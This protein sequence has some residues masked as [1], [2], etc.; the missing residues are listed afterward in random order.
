MVK[1]FSCIALR[2]FNYRFIVKQWCQILLAKV[3]HSSFAYSALGRGF[4]LSLSSF[5]LNTSVLS[6][7]LYRR[8]MDASERSLVTLC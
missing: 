4:C 5:F 2:T 1:E 8:K 7:I 3:Q 6:S